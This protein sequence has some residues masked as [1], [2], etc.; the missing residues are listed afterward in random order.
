VISIVPKK[1]EVLQELGEEKCMRDYAGSAKGFK[2]KTVGL[3]S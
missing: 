1:R 3:L 2:N